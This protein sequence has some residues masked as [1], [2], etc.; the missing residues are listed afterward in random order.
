MAHKPLAALPTLVVLISGSGSNLQAIL[1]AIQ[2]GRLQARIG[3]VISN[4]PD[5]YG[6]QRAAEAGIPTAVVDHTAFANR[7]GFDETLQQQ[8]DSFKPDLVVLAGF[9][10]ILTPAF[11]RHYQGRMLNIHPSLLP[12]YKGI[13][14]HRRVLEDGGD[15]H[16]V[17]VHFVTPELDGGP[18]IMQAKVPVLPSDSETSLAER[19]QVQEHVIYPQVVKWFV[20]GRLKLEGN[21]AMLDGNAL[22]RPIQHISGE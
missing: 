1:K 11:V 15:E 9:M 21:Q 17:S 18:L 3:A 22:T 16:G 14:T 8:I 6:L 5:V 7:E 4:R 20:E 10:R 19:V 2:T 12:L 13:H